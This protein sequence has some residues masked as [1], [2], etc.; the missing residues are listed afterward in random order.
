MAFFNTE[1]LPSIK[2]GVARHCITP[3]IG[4]SLYGYFHDRIGTYVKDDLFCH[5]MVIQGEGG[6]VVLVSLDMGAIR[7]EEVLAAKKLITEKT[8]IP[9]ENVL[10]CATHTHTGPV[11]SPTSFLKC[12]LEWLGALPG[13]I[14]D[15]VKE[16]DDKLQDA[17]LVPART[18]AEDVG[19]NRVTR[20][21]NGME[22]FSHEG[23]G[24]AGPVDKELQA[25]RVC[26]M[27]GE[28]FG[29]L[30]NFAQHAD[31]IGGATADFIS[32][33]WPGQVWRTIAQVYGEHVITVFLNG[34]CGDLNMAIDHP[35]RRVRNKLPRNLSMGRALAG[36]A[37]S[38][39]EQAEPMETNKVSAKMDFLDI[40][41]YTRDAAMFAEVEKERAESA[42]TGK[43]SYLV[44]Q[45]DNWKH[46]GE[47]AHVPVQAMQFGDIIFIGLPGEVFTRW[48][49][50]IKH[51][52]PAKFT[53]V[54]ELANGYFNYIPTTDQAQ[55]GA[56]GAKPILS[57]ALIAEGGRIIAD[58][59]QTLMYEL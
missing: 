5:V 40:P 53:F 33:D 16:A 18:I 29:M 54:V 52:S 21:K 37:I 36:L 20:L 27:E 51:W 7:Q 42:K 14:A 15:T 9:G 34:C 47:I 26:N 50:E 13:R 25:L 46:D 44:V 38:A 49:L 23:I 8:G 55:R 17:I 35:T 56:Y 12:N 28:T 2:A 11:I 30:V 32:A 57:R 43:L 48:G 45:N 10:I 3:P 41:F 58:R 24:Q 6:K 4:V 1:G 59:A 31:N 39:T 22:K 19:S